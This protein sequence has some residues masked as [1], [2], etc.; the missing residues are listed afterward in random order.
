MVTM[1]IFVL[2]IPF[3]ML[4]TLYIK[5]KAEGSVPPVLSTN[6][7]VKKTNLRFHR[8]FSEPVDG[9]ST[10]QYLPQTQPFLIS[11]EL[12]VLEASTIILPPQK[13][14]HLYIDKSIAIL[15][16]GALNL[17]E[18]DDVGVYFTGMMKSVQEKGYSIHV[19]IGADD[20]Q[21]Q[22]LVRQNAEKI[23][24]QLNYNKIKYHHIS[25]VDSDSKIN[26][27]VVGPGSFSAFIYVMGSEQLMPTVEPI[28]RDFNLFIRMSSGEV[29]SENLVPNIRYMHPIH[30]IRPIHSIHQIHPIHTAYTKYKVHRGDR[31]L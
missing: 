4:E 27:P 6:R 28:G 10:N 13:S 17:N 1:L 19:L 12:P 2:V 7:L 22:G 11:E 29:P 5:E 3:V 16:S 20:D 30:P 24:V 15:L 31:C 23:K 18:G 26:S 14:K 8:S 9:S 25:L 21:T